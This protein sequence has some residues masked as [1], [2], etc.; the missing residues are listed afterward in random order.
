ME[1]SR[2]FVLFLGILFDFIAILILQCVMGVDR[3]FGRQRT[4]RRVPYNTAVR[5]NIQF[6]LIMHRLVH[7]E[8]VFEKYF[9]LKGIKIVINRILK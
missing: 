9:Y 1:F 6:I 3:I 2:I 8:L 5:Y 7:I 4:K